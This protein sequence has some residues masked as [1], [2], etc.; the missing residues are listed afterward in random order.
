MSSHIIAGEISHVP[1]TV[2]VAVWFLGG[3]G[4]YWFSIIII[5]V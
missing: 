4:I 1:F 5:P 2:H 3:G